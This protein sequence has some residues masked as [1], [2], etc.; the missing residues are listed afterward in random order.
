MNEHDIKALID[1]RDM[2]RTEEEKEVPGYG[3]AFYYNEKGDVFCY[4]QKR[5]FDW[6]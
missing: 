4:A 6:R 1:K 2:W 5:F 3:G